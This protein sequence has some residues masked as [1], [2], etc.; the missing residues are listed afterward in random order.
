MVRAGLLALAV[1]VAAFALTTV[2]GVRGSPGFDTRYDGWLQLGGYAMAAAVAVARPVARR[3][4]R[5]LWSLVAGA[6][7]LRACAF[8][9]FVLFVRREQPSSYPSMADFAWLASAG[10]LLIAL[11]QVSRIDAPRRSRTLVLDA[12]LGGVT[13][14]A[15]AVAL[16]YGTLVRL[17]APGTTEDVVVTNLAYPLLDVALLTLAV[18]LLAARQWR[19][20]PAVAALS[21]GMAGFA[22]VDAVFLYQSAAGTYRPGSVLAAVS[23]M[24]TALMASAAWVPEDDRERQPPE[25]VIGLL[26]PIGLALVCV[27]TLLYGANRPSPLIG[28]I[29]AAGGVILAI[30]R[31]YVTLTT[32]RTEAHA[33]IA[34]KQLELLRFRSLVEATSDFVGIADLKGRLVYLNPGGRHLVGLDEGADVTRTRINDFLTAEG[35]AVWEAARQPQVLAQGSWKGE[36]TLRDFRGGPPIPVAVSTV[37]IR[38]PSTH[39][40]WLIATVQKDI[41]DRVAAERAARDLA[42]Q[43][44]LLLD[45]LVEAQETERSRIAA[46]VHDDSVQALAAVELRLLLLRNAVSGPSDDLLPVVDALR[47]TVAGA[48]DR[49]RHLLFDLESPARRTDLPTALAEVAAYVFENDRVQWRIDAEPGVELPEGAKVI[50]YRIAKEAISNAQKHAAPSE[51]VVALRADAEGIEL[52]VRDDGHGFEPTR[53]D[54]RPGHLGLTGMRDRAAI[55]GGTLEIQ[56]RH[57]GGTRVRLWL[58]APTPGGRTGMVSDARDAAGS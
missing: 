25:G 30:L 23:L 3:Q 31:C 12:L 57:G 56:S 38:H 52:L 16:L 36:S 46:D 28:M 8:V 10:V 54:N 9:V 40:P 13:A 49:L 17:T 21:T 4:H 19:I 44:Q 43:R 33:A 42:D 48:T 29:L 6:L 24:A 53:V 22:V 39:E 27:A 14:A 50:A 15:V 18:G 41:T 37:R 5:T 47:E 32:E 35:V 45:H 34:E 1:A 20:S 55:A 2:P 11:W 58:P 26:V 51:V 7:V